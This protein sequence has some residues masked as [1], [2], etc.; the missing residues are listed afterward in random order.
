M[1]FQRSHAVYERAKQLMPGGVNSPVR[2]FK[3]VGGDPF[4]VSH[5]KGAYL[6]DLDGNRYVDYINSW[7]PLVLGHAHPAVVEALR[8]QIELGTSF[9]ACTEAE[10]AL[11]ERVIKLV[12][13]I[14]MI[15]FV[16]SG[17]EAVMS[18]LRLARGFTGRNKIL[19]FTGCYHGHVDSMLVEAGSGVLTLGIPGSKGVLEGA[20]KDTILCPYNDR[21]AV[22][23]IFANIGAEIAAVI[24]EP[25]I[26]NAGFIRPLPGYLNFLRE[27]CTRYG[28]LLIFD[29]VMTGFRIALGGAQ[30]L[31]DIKPDLT[32][33]G[34]VI[35][36]GLPVGA[37]GGRRD[38]M[39]ML[40]PLGPVY[41]A[42]T[43]SGNPLAMAAGSTTLDHWSAP[44][45]FES[46]ANV[47]STLVSTL[48]A[49]AADAEI[50]I[51]C[52]YEGSMFGFFFHPGPVQSYEQAKSADV[53]RFSAFFRKALEKGVYFAPSQF[54]AGFVSL[55]HKGEPLEHTIAVLEDIFSSL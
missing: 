52:D 4:I 33:L 43:L 6:Y 9:G 27:L 15:R 30:G 47:A 49:R 46:T 37:F 42:G 19:K 3:A 1:H 40:A 13:S 12:P 14:E 35:G 7:G 17:T 16:N 36:G 41:Q 32:L 31:W 55:A 24:L 2:A 28:S 48:R 54:E 23:Q 29:E 50:P 11:A 26:G 44:G 5:G 18:A 22:E 51:V 39:A 34:K 45:V 20:A 25:L 10:S 8:R 21:A 38:I 53:E